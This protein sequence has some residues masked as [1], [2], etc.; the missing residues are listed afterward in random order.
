MG[1]A[2]SVDKKTYKTKENTIVNRLGPICRT[3]TREGM[4][5][6]CIVALE[7]WVWTE[8]AK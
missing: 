1:F 8:M 5:R 4:N 2:P 3:A 7:L 6:D